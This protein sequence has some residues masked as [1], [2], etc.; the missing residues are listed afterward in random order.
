MIIQWNGKDLEI[1]GLMERLIEAGYPETEMGHSGRDLLIPVTPLTTTV[2]DQWCEAF[3]WYK[4]ALVSTYTDS[5]TQTEM[6]ECAYQYYT[7]GETNDILCANMDTGRQDREL[8]GA[9]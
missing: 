9:R 2:I 5:G 4:P 3:G 8:V 7:G 6:Y 1:K